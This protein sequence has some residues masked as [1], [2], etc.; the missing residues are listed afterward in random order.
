MHDFIQTDLTK[1][2]YDIACIAHA[3]Q[4]D[5]GGTP[6]IN[7]PAA[8]ASRFENEELAAI[9]LLHD[10]LEDSDLT[11]KDLLSLGVPKRVV[12]TVV[13]LTR[14]P[15]ETYFNYIRRVSQDEEAKQVKLADLEH[16][17]DLSRMQI[18]TDRDRERTVRY[19]KAISI[20]KGEPSSV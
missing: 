20:L 8:V 12:F 5:K 19:K 17:C 7:H 4:V 10:V 2:A 3:D 1:R 18:I 11:A 6:A 15:E 16:N 13:V 14:M 9:A